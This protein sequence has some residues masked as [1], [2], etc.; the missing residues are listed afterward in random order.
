MPASNK[1][2]VALHVLVEGVEGG[3]RPGAAF[4]PPVLSHVD[5]LGVR[6]FTLPFFFRI[7]F[8]VFFLFPIHR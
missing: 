4:E 3:V 1:S 5:G 7:D 8:S 2:F 6:S